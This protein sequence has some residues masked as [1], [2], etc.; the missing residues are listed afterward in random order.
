M[1]V[2]CSYPPL[3]RWIQLEASSQ[4]L[5]DSTMLSPQKLI[6]DKE[7]KEEE[8]VSLKRSHPHEEDLD[9]LSENK[10]E[11]ASSGLPS[12]M[13]TWNSQ[14]PGLDKLESVP[15]RPKAGKDPDLSSSYLLMFDWENETPYTE[16]VQRWDCTHT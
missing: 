6:E 3:N 4:H 10:E 5:S 12:S 11:D 1:L 13:M 8:R 7:G 16:A 2:G 9:S 14:S 15:T